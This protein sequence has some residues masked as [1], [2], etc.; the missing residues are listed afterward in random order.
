M[1]KIYV[2]ATFDTKAQEANYI[3]RLIVEQNLPV[4]TVD[5]ST[6]TQNYA[7]NSDINSLEVAKY[8]GAGAQQ[9]FC[10]DRGKAVTAMGDAFVDFIKS[11]TD[12]GAILGIGGSGGT[13]MITKGMRSLPIGLPKIMLSTLSGNLGN[14]IG[15]SDIAM[16][17]SVT[18][19]VGLNSISVKVLSSA[20]GAIAGAYVQT[21]KAYNNVKLL[22][23]LGLTMFGVT[24]LC[25]EQLT[26]QLKDNYDCIV[27]HATGT[28]GQSMEKLL[29]NGFLAGIIDITTTE[30][31]D[32]MF[33]GVLPCTEQRFD[34]IIRTQKPAIVSCGALDMVNFGNINSVPDKYKNRK[35]YKHNSEITL[36]RTTPEENAKMGAWIAAKLNKCQGEVRFII[37]EKGISALDMDG[38]V[39]WDPAAD[40]A[41]F[42]AIESNLEQTKHRRL[43]KAPLHINSLAF[44]NLVIKE[45]SAINSLQCA[46]DKEV[47]CQDLNG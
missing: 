28:G 10:S 35:L 32:F 29:D 5:I 18:D 23:A 11:R 27:F 31:C 20:A 6:H 42:D 14:Y 36:M 8:Y 2:V 44:S 30:I 41:L 26:Q 43:I 47:A 25:I 16:M 17:Y 9:V 45:F 37:P 40:K 3:K 24:T 15:C 4:I 13:D 7:S 39:F 38:Q 22:P 34:A 33:G 46:R 21:N 1:K 19:F 12:I